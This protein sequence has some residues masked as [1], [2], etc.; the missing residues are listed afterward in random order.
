MASGKPVLAAE[1]I[2]PAIAGEFGDGIVDA[3]ILPNDGVADGLAGAAIP[4]DGGFAL[5]GDANGGEVVRPQALL[6]HGCGDDL[7][8]ASPDFFRIVL[9]PAGPRIDLLDALSARA[10][11]TLPVRSKTMKRVLVVP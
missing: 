4:E 11:T 5:V 1:A 9:H 8:R 3:R 6:V 7:L 2:L 10:A